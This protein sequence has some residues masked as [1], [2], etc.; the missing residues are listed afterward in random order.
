MGLTTE[1]REALFADII[2]TV[3][4]GEFDAGMSSFTDTLERQDLVDFVTYFEAGT[5]WAQRTGSHIDP[6][7]RAGCGSA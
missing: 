4:N 3:Q 1:Y 5:L 6:M 7:P 2:P